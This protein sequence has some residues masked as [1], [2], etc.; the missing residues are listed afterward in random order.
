[1]FPF[2]SCQEVLRNSRVFDMVTFQNGGRQIDRQ[3]Q[4]QLHAQRHYATLHHTRYMSLHW[5]HYTTL[6]ALHQFHYT[7][8]RYN[9]PH[10]TTVHYGTLQY[11]LDYNHY[12]LHSTTATT[13]VC[14][15]ATLITLHPTFII[16]SATTTRITLHYN[17]KSTPNYN[18]SYK[19]YTQTHPT[20]ACEVITATIADAPR[21][22]TPTTFRSINGFALPFAFH[23][24]QSLL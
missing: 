19:C 12:T 20:V 6:I 24:N 15:T 23:N 14:H 18:Y 22:T 2:W 7:T 4:L 8:V 13:T 11:E 21:N 9:T 17:Y 5:L 1:M 16:A 10:D 3:L